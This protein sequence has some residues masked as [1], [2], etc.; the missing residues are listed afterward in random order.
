MVEF[1]LYASL[2]FQDCGHCTSQGDGRYQGLAEQREVHAEDIDEIGYK[3]IGSSVPDDLVGSTRLQLRWP[4]IQH[5]LHD[6]RQSS[7]QLIADDKKKCAMPWRTSFTN[8]PSND[9]AFPRGC[10][11]MVLN[12]A[13]DSTPRVLR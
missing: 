2:N 10:Y 13:S 8:V 11:T 12:S 1:A 5:S 9:S 3:S 7:Y 4:R 6:Q